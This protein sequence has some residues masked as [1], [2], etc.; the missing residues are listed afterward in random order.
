MKRADCLRATSQSVEE[1]R[2]VSL[3][4]I[5]VRLFLGRSWRRSGNRGNTWSR[6]LSTSF[7]GDGGAATGA[8]LNTP[9][10]IALDGTGN[11]YVA[12]CQNQ[13]VRRVSAGGSMATIAGNGV[14]GYAG[15]GGPAT[16]AHLSCPHGVAVD[17]AGNLYI[18]DTENNRVRKVGPDGV[19]S[20][21]A[22]TGGQGLGGDGGPAAKA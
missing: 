4:R 16:Q 11:L 20:T 12:D 5:R 8:Q 10:S 13:R 19:I 17:S 14:R 1:A 7:S 6:W 3:L 9:L 18:G 2:C 22:G 15:D 21:I